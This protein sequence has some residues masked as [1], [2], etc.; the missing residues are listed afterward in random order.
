M[1][2]FGMQLYTLIEIFLQMKTNFTLCISK[3]KNLWYYLLLSEKL[4][5]EASSIR[6]TLCRTNA[7][8]LQKH[9]ILY[10]KKLNYKTLQK[11]FLTIIYEKN[12]HN[13]KQ[14]YLL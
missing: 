5:Q 13:Q 4:I 11:W 8:N 6:L 10:L 1:K 7:K 3:Q 14:L 2:I 9:F 12:N